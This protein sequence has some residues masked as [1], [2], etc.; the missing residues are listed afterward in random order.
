MVTTPEFILLP[1][2]M[3]QSLTMESKLSRMNSRRLNIQELQHAFQLHGSSAFVDGSAL[4]NAVF[5]YCK[6]IRG[7]LNSSY[8]AG[9]LSL[10]TF[11]RCRSLALYPPWTIWM[12]G[13]LSCWH[14]KL[15]GLFRTKSKRSCIGMASPN[16]PLSQVQW[17]LLRK[18]SWQLH[19]DA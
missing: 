9:K 6:T 8:K 12:T 13:A 5:M 17:S 1:L 11:L 2:L 15:M 18:Y 16:T 4:C 10:C 14:T 7:S 19:L 3:L